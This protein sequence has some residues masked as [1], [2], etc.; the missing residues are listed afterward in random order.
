[1]NIDLP[2]KKEL[3][4]YARMS[5]I[6]RDYYRLAEV[7]RDHSASFCAMCVN[8]GT[9]LV[10]SPHTHALHPLLIQ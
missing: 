2:D 9:P 6:Q 1:M 5:P 7:R 8:R 10:T 4:L 3:V